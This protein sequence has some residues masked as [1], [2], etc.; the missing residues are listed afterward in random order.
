MLTYF[1]TTSALTGTGVD[2]GGGTDTSSGAAIIVIGAATGTAG[3]DVF[4]T[5][6]QTNASTSNSY[7]IASVS[8][9]NT[10]DVDET[11]FTLIS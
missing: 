7:Q 1:E 8:G 11:D 9:V 2:L 10:G 5:T 6:D 3:V 4:F